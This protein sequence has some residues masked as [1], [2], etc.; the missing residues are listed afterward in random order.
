MNSRMLFITAITL[1]AALAVLARLAAQ[2]LY[3]QRWATSAS[4]EG[5]KSMRTARELNPLRGF[6][7]TN[8]LK[9]SGREWL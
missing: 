4:R 5:P 6:A 8:D 2:K 3:L 9:L 1:F 7:K